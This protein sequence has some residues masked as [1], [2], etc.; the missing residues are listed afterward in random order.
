MRP[1]LLAAVVLA[2]GCDHDVVPAWEPEPVVD[3]WTATHEVCRPVPAPRWVDLDLNLV[4]FGI[5]GPLPECA[6]AIAADLDL[7][8][9]LAGALSAAWSLH[10]FDLGGAERDAYNVIAASTRAIV[11][12]Y[13]DPEHATAAIGVDG[14]V[15]VI[16]DPAM[17]GIFGA[18]ILVH[19][20]AHADPD[21]P[22]H[23]GC[24]S[25][26][27]GCDED[28]RGAYG[29]QVEFLSAIVDAVEI[30]SPDDDV[31]DDWRGREAQIRGR[32]IATWADGY[33]PADPL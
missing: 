8:P 28:F 17:F 15:E 25:E 26:P 13:G 27:Q 10:A 11:P 1:T 18:S 14:V 16:D 21:A 24:Q 33:Q 31:V 30:A 23:V 2:A 5:L 19:E 7:D 6:D 32:I 9:D 20:A 4:E 29:A 22:L 12:G 3:L